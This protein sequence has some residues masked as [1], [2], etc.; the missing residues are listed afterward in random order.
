LMAGY[1]PAE[2]IAVA[3]QT[4][5]HQLGI[6][7]IRR[8]HCLCHLHVNKSVWKQA[9]EVTKKIS[10]LTMNISIHCQRRSR[11]FHRPSNYAAAQRSKKG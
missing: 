9:K 3:R 11:P 6:A 8:F 4:P 7:G 10:Y 5:G 2:R 1:N